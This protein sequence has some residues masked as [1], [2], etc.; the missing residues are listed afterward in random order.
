MIKIFNFSTNHL[1]GDRTRKSCWKN[2][3]KVLHI[4]LP[5]MAGCLSWILGLAV[6]FKFLSDIANELK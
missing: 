5:E 1:K 4:G 3:F 2:T 6:G